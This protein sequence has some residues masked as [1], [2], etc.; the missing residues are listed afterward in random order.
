MTRPSRLLVDRAFNFLGSC[1]G[2]VVTHATW[3]V[4]V[5]LAVTAGSLMLAKNL[6]IDTDLANLIPSDYPS[7]VALER[8]RSTIGGEAE[9]AVAIESPSFEANLAYAEALIPQVLGLVRAR[10]GEPFFQ[11]VD[12]R[13][14][15]TFLKD[16]ALYFATPAELDMLEDW[17][18]T[19]IEDAKLEANP[20]MFDL[21]DEDDDRAAEQDSVGEE[22]KAVYEQIVSKEYPISADS[23]TMVLQFFPTNTSSDI[24]FIR[25]AYMALDSVTA[26]LGPANY[27]ADMEITTAGRLLRH[28]VEVE[29]IQEDVLSSFGSGAGAVLL[30]VVLYFMYKAYVARVGHVWSTRV[31]VTQLLRAPSMALVIGLP[32]IMSLSWTFALA[33]LVHGTLNLMTSTLG[34]VLF[35]LGID[36]GI[37]FYGRYA[38]ERSDGRSV[39]DAVRVTFRSTGQAITIGAFTTSLGLFV[40]VLADFKGFSQFGF[41]AGS[42]ILFALVAMIFVLPA[43]LAVFERMGLLNLSISGRKADTD[44]RNRRTTFP[45]CRIALYGSV[46]AEIG[47]AHV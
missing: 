42:G 17:L 11:R 22:L 39:L 32:L 15:V 37:H 9:A 33:W 16:N 4:I 5:A 31:F 40:L 2:G 35:G 18:R 25:D 7:A 3:V 28:M 30:F 45:G 8:L 13:K 23:T 41:I 46:A 21:E 27:H 10:T 36:F 6:R 12:F 26:A 44:G 47:R 20:F 29:T 34:L 38:E 1:V 14:D 43:L 19:K 24:A